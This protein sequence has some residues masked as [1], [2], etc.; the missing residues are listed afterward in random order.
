VAGAFGYFIYGNILILL[1]PS[2]PQVFTDSGL[3]GLI[4]IEAFLFSLVW[5]FL[6]IRGWTYGEIGLQFQVPDLINGV[7][8]T[9]LAHLASWFVIGLALAMGLSFGAGSGITAGSLGLTSI[10][11]LSVFN[12]LFEEVFVC[13][14]IV[15]AVA[16]RNSAW[17]GIHM[18]VAIRLL[19]H[20]YQGPASAGIIPI[21]LIFAY[22]Y[23]RTGRLW[24]VVIA[25]GL[26]DF[27][28]LT[29]LMGR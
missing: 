13:G 23:A 27:A 22:W 6:R 2:A 25:H 3:Y 1:R 5:L 9:V 24:P 10:I 12:P 16:R 15:T 4:L 17:T 20:L 18:S 11:A 14:Y 8:L 21:G 26:L 7:V 19:Y 29:A 28:G